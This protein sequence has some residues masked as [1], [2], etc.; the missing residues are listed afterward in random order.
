MRTTGHSRPDQYVPNV[1]WPPL[2]AATPNGLTPG[3]HGARL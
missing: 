1:I 3:E 2:D